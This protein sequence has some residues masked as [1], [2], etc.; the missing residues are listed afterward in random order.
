MIDRKFLESTL[1][2]LLEWNYSVLGCLKFLS[3]KRRVSYQ[4][5]PYAIVRGMR[6]ICRGDI[7]DTSV[8]FLLEI[9]EKAGIGYLRCDKKH[10]KFVWEYLHVPVFDRG[11]ADKCIGIYFHQKT[12]DG[13]FP[14]LP[15][16]IP[17]GGNDFLKLQ[18][19]LI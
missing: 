9:F 12:E 5:E 2:H 11:M 17:R 13:K 8:Y 4:T 15:K 18:E 1:N 14:T 10:N 6:K 16:R 19:K 7:T 3:I